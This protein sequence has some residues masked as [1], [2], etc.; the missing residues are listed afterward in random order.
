MRPSIIYKP[1]KLFPMKGIDG[2]LSTNDTFKT[3]ALLKSTLG[4]LFINRSYRI[5]K[6]KICFV[7]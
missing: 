6:L 5:L 4:Q 7:F 3:I 1:I 2:W